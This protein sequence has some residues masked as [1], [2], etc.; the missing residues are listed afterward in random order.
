MA[1]SGAHRQR[2]IAPLAQGRFLVAGVAGYSQNPTGASISEQTT[3]LL[4]VLTLTVAKRCSLESDG[5]LK[6]RIPVGAGN[7]RWRIAMIAGVLSVTCRN[8]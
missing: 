8:H 5:T 3:P 4:A 2:D 1:R 7:A 6:Q